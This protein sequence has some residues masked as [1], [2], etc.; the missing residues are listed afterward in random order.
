RNLKELA[1]Y[2]ATKGID[3]DMK[4]REQFEQWVTQHHNWFDGW[5]SPALSGMIYDK[6]GKPLVDRDVLF[7][8][9]TVRPDQLLAKGE[10][11]RITTGLI[12][13]NSV[14]AVRIQLA[15][16]ASSTP[17]RP[18]GENLRVAVSV[19]APDGKMR[20]LAV[21]F[22]D[23]TEKKPRYDNGVETLGVAV[24]WRLPQLR[25]GGSPSAVYLLDPP[26]KLAPKEKLVITVSGEFPAS[27]R[28]ALSPFGARAPLDLNQS[29]DLK[30]ALHNPPNARTVAQKKLLAETWL[31]ST[32]ADRPAFD[33]YKQL[34]AALR[35]TRD[36]KAWS[37]VTQ[38]VDPLTVRVLPRGNW[39][40]ESGPVVLPATPSFLP[41]REESTPERRLTRLDLAEYIVSKENP[42]TARTVM[43]RLWQQFF[44]TALSASVDDLGSQGE[45]PSHPELLDWIA[46]EFRDSDWDC[47][48][49]IKLFVTSATY[50]QSS[51]LRPELREIDPANRLLASQ[52]PRRLE[53]EFVRDNAL[54][55]AGVLNVDQIGGP[56][57]KPYQPP[58]YYDALQFPT[59]DYVATTGPDQWR[60]GVYM[61]RQRTFLHPMLANFDAPSRD[62]CAAARTV[63][64]TPQQALTL[65]NDPTFVEAARLFA[66]RVLTG[67]ATGDD[68]RLAR[69]FEIAMARPPKD[70]EK[71]SLEAF[72]AT[73][74]DYYRD[75]A[76]DAGKLLKTGYAPPTQGDSAE[77]AAWTNLCRVLLN[78]Q[79][80]IT[81]Y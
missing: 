67:E 50:R 45:P 62:E 36:G 61:H 18:S 39:Q 1:A 22:A 49:M 44:G 56:S 15:E 69:A 38:A 70:K 13:A 5:E 17:I 58:G 8:A 65:L 64:N 63:S 35:E 52:N 3:T 31:L 20:K 40:D 29:D 25:T 14:G 55:I 72:L 9:D 21:Y 37:M 26:A 34:A 60:R 77:L 68:V 33:R 41:G 66:S 79:E 54:F 19:K 43:N 47:K 80:V 4:V 2:A 53:A 27:L 16:E 23:A 24:E 73:Q 28:V 48:H 11:L 57:M 10:E 6:Q 51:V 75:H 30:S 12:S 7:S 42:I 78:S 32:A 74:R 46:S 71:E 76:D 59:R 81:R